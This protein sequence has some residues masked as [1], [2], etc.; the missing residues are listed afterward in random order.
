MALILVKG[1]SACT[2]AQVWSCSERRASLLTST[3]LAD[4]LNESCKGALGLNK[5]FLYINMKVAY[6]SSAVV[7]QPIISTCCSMPGST[8]LEFLR[9]VFVKARGRLPGWVDVF[10]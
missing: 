5:D 2:S 8:F 10:V 9:A 6:A 3:A 1:T 4:A 7:Q